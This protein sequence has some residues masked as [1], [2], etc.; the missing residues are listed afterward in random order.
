MR[1]GVCCLSVIVLVGSL[2]V[3]PASAAFGAIVQLPAV[4]PYSPFG[5][6]A[7]V[8][9]TFGSGDMASIFDIRLRRPGHG[10]IKQKAVLVDPD[11]ASSPFDV[12]FSWQELSVTSPTDYV[13]EVLRQDDGSKIT[14]GAFTLLPRLVSDLSA[15]P[16]PFYPLVQDGYKDRTRVGFSLAADSVD[17]VARVFQA[18]DFGRCCGPEIRTENLGPLA[19]GSR[20]WTWDGTADDA[21]TVPKGTY[22]A[23]VSATDID[24]A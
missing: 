14:S 4:T 13:I 12:S 8:T 16:S 7:T 15:T 22:F 2:G 5:G 23:K 19:N 1:K 6:P 18:D 17:T 10:V 9:F 20:A 3:V 21:S 24:G 11:T